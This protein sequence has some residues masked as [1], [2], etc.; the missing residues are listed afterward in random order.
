M[1]F[2]RMIA[3]FAPV[4]C[5][6]AQTPPPKPAPAPATQAQ[7]AVR[8]PSPNPAAAPPAAAAAT[9]LASIPP[10][11]VVITVGEEK[12]TAGEFE[13]LIQTLPEQYRGST[14]TAAGRKQFVDNYVRLKVLAQEARRRH[15]DQDPAF[16]AQL[17]LQRDN[18]LAA[19]A[20]NTLNQQSKVSDEQISEYYTQHKSEFQTVRA[21]HILIRFKGSP[22]PVRP[23]QKD[24]TDEEALAKA[25][26]VRKE[27]LAGG[28]FAAVAKRDSDDAGSGLQ[29][30][31]LGT[32]H[33]GQMVPTFEEAAFS[34][35]IGQLSEPVKT[36]FGY[37]LI[38]VSQR[39]SKSL[40]DSRAEIEKKLRPEAA[41]K[42]VES[43][44]KSTNVV[45]DPQLLGEK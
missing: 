4:A 17:A 30:G 33:R 29:G 35:P 6:L 22:A 38:K 25:Q 5:L 15:L 13:K 42:S 10:D 39:D 36:T 37:H 20:Y 3:S 12:V 11:K 16:K 14:N 43:L 2:F 34:L 9:P 23:G 8:P 7:P 24:L 18:L 40:A 32:F 27:L 45:I 19:S 26:A 31:D 44:Q 21:S 1:K 41:M 28:D